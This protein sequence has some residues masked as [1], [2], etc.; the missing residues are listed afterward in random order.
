MMYQ[1][2]LN[3]DRP[4]REIVGKFVPDGAFTKMVSVPR[5]RLTLTRPAYA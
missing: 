5:K 1:A 4:A 3:H 2:P